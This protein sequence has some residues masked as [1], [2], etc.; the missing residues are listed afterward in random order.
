M[1]DAWNL[2]SFRKMSTKEYTFDNGRS[3][4]KVTISRIDKFLVSQDIESRGSRIEAATSVRKLSNHSPLVIT[5]WGQTTAP[6]KSS[7]YSDTSLLEEEES[8]TMMF[9]AWEGDFP[10]PT[11]DP[12]WTTWLEATTARVMS[13]NARLTRAKRRLKR[14]RV[15]TH[16][17]K[18][19]LAKAQL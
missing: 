8:K 9:K 7:R 3:D 1:A 13:C 5:I 4:P 18:V 11:K 2:D 16:A 14:T 12:E 10:L 17:K 15:R 19:Q 6:S